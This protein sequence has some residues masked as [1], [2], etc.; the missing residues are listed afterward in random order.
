MPLGRPSVGRSSYAHIK[1]RRD[2]HASWV[3]LKLLLK[4]KSDDTL[5]CYL[6]TSN[7]AV[8]KLRQDSPAEESYAMTHW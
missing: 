3:E 7:G 6:L 8:S 5:A 2:T 1:L 4:L